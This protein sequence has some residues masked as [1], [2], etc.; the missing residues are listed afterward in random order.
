M[1]VC[2]YTHA[3][4]LSPPANVTVLSVMAT[5]ITLT[6]EP[7]PV[8]TLNGRLV[9]YNL[10]YRCHPR[11]TCPTQP[12]P[13]LHHRVPAS[14]YEGK[15]SYQFNDL[16]PFMNYSFEVTAE[17]LAGS[18]PFSFSVGMETEQTG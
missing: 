7:P 1:Y 8:D 17:T 10:R 4:P 15:V 14:E 9:G 6:W 16:L 12:C 3:V 5:S 11:A 13:E 2:T 18:G